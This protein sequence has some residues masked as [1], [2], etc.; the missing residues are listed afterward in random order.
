MD[1]WMLG[2][3]TGLLDIL[4]TN[5]AVGG[6]SPL[7]L[8]PGRETQGRS[9]LHH[10][11]APTEPADFHRDPG[12][13]HPGWVPEGSLRQRK[14]SSGNESPQMVAALECPLA[15]QDMGRGERRNPCRDFRR[16]KPRRPTTTLG[17]PKHTPETSTAQPS[18]LD[19]PMLTEPKHKVSPQAS[20]PCMTGC[21][22]HIQFQAGAHKI[23][24]CLNWSLVMALL[25][26]GSTST[27]PILWPSPRPFSPAAT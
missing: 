17:S 18:T 14:E 4:S 9:P 12:Q 26:S 2:W 19:E 21:A 8:P 22:I 1:G 16:E 24:M 15:T 23:T 13:S 6:V 11:D 7:D 25:D 3:M 5:K 27:W 20:N 10:P